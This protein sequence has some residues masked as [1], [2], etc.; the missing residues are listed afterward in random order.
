MRTPGWGDARVRR[1][2]AGSQ[3]AYAIVLS[4]VVAVSVVMA[5]ASPG[6]SVMADNGHETRTRCEAGVT[7]THVRS[8]WTHVHDSRVTTRRAEAVGRRFAGSAVVLI[9]GESTAT[10]WARADACAGGESSSATARRTTSWVAIREGTAQD[11]VAGT[12]V[13]ARRQA[14]AAAIGQARHE[15]RA[16]AI[17]R[18]TRKAVSAAL[19]ASSA[20]ASS[21]RS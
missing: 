9:F 20:L 16:I 12:R 4:L 19:A 6:L 1:A 5:T 2:Q 21:D 14:V 18:A 11:V 7:R 3:P 8:A 10:V 17:R 13:R 15:L